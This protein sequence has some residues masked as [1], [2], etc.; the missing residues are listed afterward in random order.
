M[1]F[2]T[3]TTAVLLIAALS[4]STTLR[5][6]CDF[7]EIF[8][9]TIG[10]CSASAKEFVVPVIRSAANISVVSN[11][12]VVIRNGSMLK[13]SVGSTYLYYLD[14]TEDESEEFVILDSGALRRGDGRTEAP[15]SFCLD[16]ISS[17]DVVLPFF[18][19]PSDED[20]QDIEGE[21][22]FALYPKFMFVSVPFLLATFLVYAAIKQLQNL[23]G[24]CLMSHVAALSL[25]YICL[26]VVQ[27]ASEEINQL[28]CTS[29]GFAVQFFF[30]ATFF[31]LNVMCIDIYWAFSDLR[32]LGG[33][34]GTWRDQKKLMCYSAYAW[35]M[36]LLILGVTIAVD[37]MPSVP[38]TSRFKPAM[39][40]DKCFFRGRIAGWT[41]FYGPMAVILLMNCLLF[42]ITAFHLYRHRRDACV[43]KRGDSRRHGPGSDKERFN[44]YLKLFL[45]MGINWL[46]EV[47]SF[48]F[49]KDVP[50]YLWYLTDITNTLQGVFIFLIFVW[51]RRV[52]QLIWDKLCKGKRAGSS[53]NN[54]SST[55]ITTNSTRSHHNS[56]KM[57][58]IN[59]IAS[60]PIK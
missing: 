36:P 53:A 44:L 47:V 35:G 17:R 34:G 57:N 11:E 40:L 4:S 58:N 21:G 51:K 24:Q 54:T 37:L 28:A 59:N 2:V 15:G 9:E 26:C 25:S 20:F 27:V 48:T 6:C 39:G 1:S 5:K 38:T 18:C 8:N 50:R 43:L 52:R 41:Y 31:W 14:P 23:H 13:C 60:V 22:T 42:A 30:L 55:S 33:A 16:M 7:G 10:R 45:V 32:S 3:T 49:H 19:F 29:L 46:S 12:S 56:I